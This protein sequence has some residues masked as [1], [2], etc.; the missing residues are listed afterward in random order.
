MIDVNINGVRW[1]ITAALPVFRT[2]GFGLIA[3][4]I[5]HIDSIRCLTMNC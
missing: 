1:G 4:P 2:Q 5:D 3:P